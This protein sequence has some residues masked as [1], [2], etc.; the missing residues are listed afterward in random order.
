MITWSGKGYYVLLVAIGCQILAMM[1]CNTIL[2][3]ITIFKTHGWPKAAAL[4][5]AAAVIWLL[6]KSLRGRTEYGIHKETGERVPY[7]PRD[8]LFFIPMQYWA[9]VLLLLA[10]YVGVFNPQ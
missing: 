2:G 9:I 5:A 10:V 7:T 6:A 1:A 3:D 4:I 8:T